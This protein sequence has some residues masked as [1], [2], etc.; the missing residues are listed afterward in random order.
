M[1]LLSEALS[2]SIDAVSVSPN[3]RFDIAGVYGFGRG[4]FTREPI[5]GSETSYP[6]LH[7]L[8]AGSVVL[9]R[10]KAFEGAIAVV[11][12]RLDGWFLSPEFP[13]FTIN[14]DV[15]DSAYLQHLFRWPGFWELLRGESRGVGARRER[16]SAQRMLSIKA[17]LPDSIDEQQEIAARLDRLYGARNYSVERTEHAEGL[18]ASLHNSLCKVEAPHVRVGSV[19]ELSRVSV[20]IDPEQEY[21]QIGVYSFG[22]GVIRREPQLGS[23]LSKL[24]YYRIPADA[25]VLSNIQAWEKAIALSEESDVDRVASQRFLPYVPKKQDDIDMGYMRYYF[26]SEAGHPLILK[27]SPGT[28]ARNRTLGIKAFENLIISLPDK[29]TQLRI[30]SLLDSAYEIIRRMKQRNQELDALYQAALGEVF[31]AATAS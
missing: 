11:P 26:L 25:L 28:T 5:R 27:S 9:S 8:H 14:P 18:V 16:V 3:D 2:I 1:K 4:M 31:G 7:R 17:P 22:K 20:S 23:T 24:K 15:A 6:K 13:T 10:L 21:S 30:S 12:E 29:N 19:M